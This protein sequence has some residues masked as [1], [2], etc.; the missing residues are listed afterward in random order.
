MCAE[1]KWNVALRQWLK[2][3]NSIIEVNIKW[4][5]NK[6]NG[7]NLIHRLIKNPHHLLLL[8]SVQ[9]S[10]I[11]LTH[12]CYFYL[13]QSATPWCWWWRQWWYSRVYRTQLGMSYGNC[14]CVRVSGSRMLVRNY[15]DAWFAAL[16][17]LFIA[18]K[19]HCMCLSRKL[20]FCFCYD[21]NFSFF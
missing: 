16:F 21:G 10:Q 14:S 4:S 6:I 8:N 3:N 18:I 15:S 19:L 2:F 7:I 5:Y 11:I 9:T 17:W 13:T 20:T 12:K 1:L